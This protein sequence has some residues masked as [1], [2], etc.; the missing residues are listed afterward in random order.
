MIDHSVIKR[1]LYISVYESSA[2]DVPSKLVEFIKWSQEKLD[3]IP[4]AYHDEVCLSF[5]TDGDSPKIKIDYSRMET[6]GELQ[7]RLQGQ[8]SQEQLRREKEI[9][10]LHALKAKYP[11]V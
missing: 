3:S 6:E 1:R 5:Y 8:K 2:Y 7:N 11:G 10:L 9:Q 4:V